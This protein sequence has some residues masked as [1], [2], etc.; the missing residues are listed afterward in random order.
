[1]SIS[2]IKIEAYVDIASYNQIEG[3]AW[4]PDDPSLRL[5]VALV[6][7]KNRNLAVTLANRE[8]RDLISALVG[9]GLYGFSFYGN[10]GNVTQ[11]VFSAQGSE[12]TV[13][14]SYEQPEKPAFLLIHSDDYLLN[15]LVH[16][17]HYK[18]YSAAVA[19]YISDGL[20]SA[21]KLKKLC[22]EYL[23]ER[24]DE[25]IELLEFASGYGRVTRHIDKSRFN[26][27]AS[28]IHENAIAFLEKQ[29]K[30][31]TFLS[32]TNP[33]DFN[34]P[35]LYDV[36]FAL[37]FFSHMPDA[38]F[39]SWIAKLFS[40]LK[41][42]GLLIFTTHGRVSNKSINMKL[43]NGF[44]FESYS[45]QGDLDAADY[46]STVSELSYV[47]EVLRRHIGEDPIL[48]SEGFWWKHQ[49]LYIVRKS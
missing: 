48:F 38:T 45:D 49:D 34:P 16:N 43:K 11:V 2:K 9:D 20:D 29:F 24:K 36:V 33:K 10:L 13:S 28:D 47:S 19:N 8:R 5:S 21:E 27:T 15:F 7:S 41:D 3:W 12:Y 26:I 14:V 40:C 46:G 18:S 30:V 39:G 6:G 44:G 37:S 31:K 25:R 4:C 35:L 17:E 42:N 1:M 23:P 22:V 32:A